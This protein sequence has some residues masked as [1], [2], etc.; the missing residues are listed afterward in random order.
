[1]KSFAIRKENDGSIYIDK[2][3]FDKFT[4]EDLGVYGYIMVEGPE[5]CETSDFN[6]DLSFNNDK[7]IK[8]KQVEKDR[9]YERLAESLI[10]ERYTSSQE[11]AIQRKRDIEPT[12]FSE[13]F[14]FVEDCLKKAKET[15]YKTNIIQEE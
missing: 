11:F 10:R 13:Y 12:K 8:R 15:I 1:M 3:F 14:N 2:S 7:Y 6:E 4:K 5:D 9:E